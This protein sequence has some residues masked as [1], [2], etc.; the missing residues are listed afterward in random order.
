MSYLYCHVCNLERAC[1][2]EVS[3]SLYLSTPLTLVLVHCSSHTRYNRYRYLISLKP[4]Q[5]PIDGNII[6][7]TRDGN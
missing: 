5:V 7:G 3:F 4:F 1:K 6:F 2:A